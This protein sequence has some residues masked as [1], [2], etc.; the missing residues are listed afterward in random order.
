[1][2]KDTRKL[3]DRSAERYE[4]PESVLSAVVLLRDHGLRVTPQRLMLVEVVRCL[5]GH[6]TADQV[7]GRIRAVYPGVSKVSVY[8][9]LD[10]LREQGLVTCTELGQHAAEYEWSGESRHHHLVCSHCGQKQDVPD[11]EMDA[12]RE[13]LAAGYGFHA[14]MDH[15]AIWG[16]CRACSG[17]VSPIP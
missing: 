8:R 6:F 1:M 4:A 11:C 5:H 3:P 17:V 10:T 7:Y 14:T 12:L 15:L 9:G 2:G 13:R 16:L